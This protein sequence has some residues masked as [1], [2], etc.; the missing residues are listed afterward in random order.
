MFGQLP[1]ETPY[2]LRFRFAGFP[3]RISW[4]FWLMSIVLGYEL[5][6]SVDLLFINGASGSPG[7][8]ALLL[9]WAACIMVS[10]L[11]H[12]LGHTIAFRWYGIE[13]HVL[14][15]H[16][17]GLAI[18]S[19]FRVGGRRSGNLDPAANLIISAAGPAAQI[20][21]AVLLVLVAAAMGYRVDALRW[22]PGPLANWTAS[23]GGR[24]L[25]SAMSFALVNFYVLPS[26][27]W[28]LLNLL[29]VLPLDGGRIAEAVLAMLGHG[30]HIAYQ[31]SLVT[32]VVIALYAFQSGQM[33]LAI[34]FVWM[35][36]D[37]YQALQSG[38]R[39]S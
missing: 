33:F 18:P 19:G 8:A 38:G 21:S 27:F 32:A 34:F 13:S 10:I 28:G 6:R 14:L 1:G 3:I 37:A 25:D 39:W 12:E 23:L 24:P 4:T 16:F 17:G 9:I 15:Y 31:L 26:I 11:I 20:G 2:D 5:V 7:V 29:P 35:G 36:I 30:K 22:L